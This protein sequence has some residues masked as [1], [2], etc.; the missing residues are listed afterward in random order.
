MAVTDD[1]KYT[2]AF[3]HTLLESVKGKTLGEVHSL[4]VVSLANHFYLL[5]KN[6]LLRGFV[7]CLPF[8]NGIQEFFLF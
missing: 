5:D 1:R 4:P 6:I 2:K 8:I 3:V 7:L